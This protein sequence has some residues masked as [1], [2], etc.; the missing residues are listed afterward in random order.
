MKSLVILFCLAFYFSY[1]VYCQVNKEILTTDSKRAIK[2]YRLAG[3]NIISSDYFQAEKSALEAIAIDRQFVEAYLLLGDIYTELKEYAKAIDAYTAAIGINPDFYPEVY[4]LIGKLEL[5][6]GLYEKAR[7]HF[8]VCRNYPEISQAKKSIIAKYIGDC[9]FAIK[10]QQ[11]PVVFEPVNLGDSIN[12]PD[13]EYVNAITVDGKK[14]Y[15]TRRKPDQIAGEANRYVVNEDFYVSENDA[16]FWR[17]ATSLGPSVNTID[18]EGALCISPDG[19][20]IFFAAC[21]R[22]DGY[23]SCDLYFSK[24]V[25][26][27]WTTSQNLGPVI[28]SST[29]ESQPCFSSDG[30]TLYFCSTRKGGIGKSDI[31]KSTIQPDGKWSRPENLGD[32]VNTSEDEMA[33]Y[34]HPDG[35]TLYFSS[36]G[37]MGMGGYDLFI[38][39]KD[40]K[41]EWSMPVNLGYPLNTWADEINIIID[42][43]GLN[44]YFSSGMSGG[45]GKS[46]IYSFVIDSSIKPVPV[47]YLKGVVYDAITN[48]RLGSSFTLIDLKTGDTLV[49]SN[50]DPVTG[51][52][53]LCLPSDKNYSLHVAKDKYL[54][55]SDNFTLIGRNTELSPFFKDIPLKPLKPGETVVLNNI[56]FDF[57]KSD[58]KDESQSELQKLISFLEENRNLKIEISGHTDNVGNLSYNSDL[59]ERRAKAVYDFLVKCGIPSSRLDYRGYGSSQ[60]IDSNDTPEGRNHNRRTEFKIIGAQ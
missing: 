24:K 55:Y 25:G 35:Q 1:P 34:I 17:K 23:G 3:K 60:P 16:G 52:F 6:S 53:I 26:E 39:R 48:I 59:S 18:N 29:W 5:G 45:S 31:W 57:D 51:E 2:Y 47:T 22:D 58:I 33:P 27:G 12:T 49:E 21:N 15:L 42:A 38:S 13:D 20:Y 7:E 37:H 30:R 41:G 32:L 11:N 9:D 50:S 46:D 54:F 44:A 10:L 28:N 14:L 40:V 4:L 36:R 8:T 43:T 19:K 56:F